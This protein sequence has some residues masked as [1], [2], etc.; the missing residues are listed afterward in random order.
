VNTLGKGS[1]C[2]R[3]SC[4]IIL[5]LVIAA[6]AVSEGGRAQ[7]SGSLTRCG[8]CATGS[9]RASLRLD[10]LSTPQSR[11]VLLKAGIPG[12]PTASR[13]RSCCHRGLRCTSR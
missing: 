3:C 11:D 4:Q 10:L 7:Q 9:S 5:M 2:S 1:F 13:R 6:A 8:S 12:I